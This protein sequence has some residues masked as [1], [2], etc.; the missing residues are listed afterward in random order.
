VRVEVEVE[1]RVLSTEVGPGE[2]WWA[3]ACRACDAEPAAVDLS[4][5][6][7]RFVV[8]PLLQVTLRPLTR[9]DLPD[10]I[11]WRGRE[12]V[13]RWWDPLPASYE[14]VEARYLPRIEGT[15][16]TS[17][18][19]W[20][21]NGRSIGLVQDYVVRDHPGFALLTPDPDAV[22][23]DYLVGEVGWTGRGVGTRALWAWVRHAA[24]R[25]PDARRLFAAP[26]HRNRA[27]LRALAKVGFVEGT[28]FDQPQEDGSVETVVGCT[29]DVRD[30]LG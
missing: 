3:A 23:G 16:P 14:A 6:V 8:D 18:W 17:M 22:G 28:W 26:D 21:A 4:G 10:L 9:G 25:H 20:E 15:D 7:K 11:T 29:L 2:S 5:D 12:H 1:G 27:S 24:E 30:V 13:R 19:V